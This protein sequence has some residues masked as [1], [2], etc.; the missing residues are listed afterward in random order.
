MDA[1]YIVGNGPHGHIELFYSMRS[2]AKHITGID[3]LYIIG[4]KPKFLNDKAIYV[5]AY[6]ADPLNKE[7]NIYL[8]MMQACRLPGITEQ[9]FFLHDDHFLLQNFIVDAFGYYHKPIDLYR[10]LQLKKSTDRYRISMVNTYQELSNRKLPYKHYD[11]HVPFIA[12]KKLFPFIMDQFNWDYSCGY[13][14]KSLYC[15]YLQLASTEMDDFKF[16]NC[17]TEAQIMSSLPHKIRFS[18]DHSAL[19]DCMARVFRI[20][21]PAPSPWETPGAESLFSQF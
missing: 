4:T 5:Q 6:D 7:K 16:R 14:I 9:I 17:L 15:N 19:N 8:K 20:L 13:L 18:T 12:D 10:G 11:I 2:L 21:Y 3:N 1:V